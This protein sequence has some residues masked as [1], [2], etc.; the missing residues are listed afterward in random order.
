[1]IV[2]E[3]VHLRMAGEDPNW[4]AETVAR[5]VRDA[6]GQERVR[7]FR[8]ASVASDLLIHLEREVGTES[9]EAFDPS[10]GTTKAG[11][12]GTRLASLLKMYGMVE[13]SVWLRAE[14]GPPE[15]PDS[16]K[17]GKREHDVFS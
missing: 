15:N 10:M 4:L 9:G 14:Y 7:V 8:H 17:E 2:L 1:M 12:L 6:H 13:H 11:E 16:T 3:V 5:A